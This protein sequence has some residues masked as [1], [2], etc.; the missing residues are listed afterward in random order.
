[1][2]RSREL[3]LFRVPIGIYCRE[4]L[5]FFR[6]IVERENRG[7]G[8][9]GN[10]GSAINA[11]YRADV[12]LSFT[13]IRRLVFARMDTI[14]RTYIHARGVF[15]S[16]AGLSNHVGHLALLERFR[17]FNPPTED[18][19]SAHKALTYNTKSFEV[20]VAPAFTHSNSVALTLARA[21]AYTRSSAAKIIAERR[22]RSPFSEKKRAEIRVPKHRWN[23]RQ[24][25]SLSSASLA[26]RALFWRRWL[27][28]CS[29]PTH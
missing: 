15:R 2:Q 27:C 29:I 6:Q 1:M 14:D 3:C 18:W 10:T 23:Q 8:A 7:H 25:K 17:R 11:L 13:F 5:P 9:D 24:A 19:G 21:A 16:D 4:A 26:L 28:A 22:P 12:K 20:Q